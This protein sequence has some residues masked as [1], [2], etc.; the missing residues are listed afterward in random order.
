M[1]KKFDLA[2][3]LSIT[4]AWLY[5]LGAVY[6][7][8]YFRELGLAGHH[9]QSSF[10]AVLLNGFGTLFTAGIGW[11]VKLAVF[12]EAAVILWVVWGGIK[13]SRKIRARIRSARMRVA[14]NSVNSVG[15]KIAD[16]MDQGFKTAFRFFLPLFFVLTFFMIVMLSVLLSDY[17]GKVLAKQFIEKSKKYDSASHIVGLSNG[18]KINLGPLI[19]CDDYVCIYM[20]SDRAVV[21]K[22]D[23]I[24]AETATFPLSK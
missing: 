3:A 24:N 11:V 10:E 7:Q 2:I 15:R 16:G 9:L 19:G 18:N 13:A 14:R 20:A 17:Q 8:S 21:I 12:L 5:F 1:S 22:R 23:I 6:N 4:I